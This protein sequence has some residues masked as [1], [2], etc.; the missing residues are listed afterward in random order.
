M[1]MGGVRP[2]WAKGRLVEDVRIERVEAGLAPG[3]HDNVRCY[4]CVSYG[5]VLSH[6][7]STFEGLSSLLDE[8]FTA[9]QPP[10]LHRPEAANVEW[11]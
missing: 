10:E 1:G 11:L 9:L 6:D 2:T 7:A 4:G 8:S 5:E 3:S